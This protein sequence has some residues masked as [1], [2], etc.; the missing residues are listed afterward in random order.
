MDTSGHTA[1]YYKL[2]RIAEEEKAS[3]EAALPAE[4]KRDGIDLMV[5]WSIIGLFVIAGSAAV[6]SM[7]TI[8]MPITLAV[9]VGIVLGRA[10]DSLAKFGLPPIMG[11]LLLALFFVLGL[12][13]VVSALLG[14]MT[15]L[16]QKAPAL[17]EGVVERVSTLHRAFRMAA[18]GG[19][20]RNRRRS[21]CRHRHE[22]RWPG[23]RRCRRRADAGPGPDADFPCSTRALPARSPASAQDHHPCLQQ[24]GAT[25]EHDPDH[26]RDR[27]RAG[28]VFFDR[29]PDLSGAWRRHHAHRA[30]RRPGHAT[31]LGVVCL[32]LQLH[33]LSRRDHDD[34]GPARAAG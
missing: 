3:V 23:S 31:A 15:D 4:P 27:N 18:P 1:A 12:A 20:A 2:K 16:A 14:P 17:A 9:V 34:A 11:G 29:E 28:A 7:E 13:S 8:L 6:Y 5:A 30:G 10:A 22:E 24:P 26:E 33:S 19:G 32:R 25:P 21:P